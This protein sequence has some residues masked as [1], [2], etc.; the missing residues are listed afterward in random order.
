MSN[1]QKE[2][3]YGK[4]ILVVDDDVET[5]E[6]MRAYLEPDYEV[7]TV[8][9][10]RFALDY[11]REYPTDMIILDVA[12]PVMDGF[13]TLQAIRNLEEGINIPIMFVTGKGNRS[14]VLES[15]CSGIDAF[16]VKPVKKNDLLNKIQYIFSQQNKMS[17]KR[18]VLAIDDDAAYLK[19]IDTY[20]KES[21]NVVMINSTKLAM[22]YLRGHRPDVILLDY[23]MPLYSGSTILN[24]IRRAEEIKN[25][26]V[27]MLTGVS[28]KQSVMEC[29]TERPD[30]FL[31]KPVSK[32]ELIRGI[33]SVLGEKENE[34]K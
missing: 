16:L 8:S 34:G 12:M 21:F 11:I 33:Y 31:L 7:G 19:I 5:L 6:I 2:M 32:I 26:P 15:I 10:G 13:Q 18:T 29:L 20:L 3:G 17:H 25:V 4:R 28:D 14:I 24:Y 9:Y 23:Q 30:R 1:S 22:E 27:I